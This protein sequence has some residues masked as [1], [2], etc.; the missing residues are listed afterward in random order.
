MLRIPGFEPNGQKRG[1]TLPGAARWFAMSEHRAV[2]LE[3]QPIAALAL[4]QHV[5]RQ[6]IWGGGLVSV[7]LRVSGESGR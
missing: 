2:A 7:R 5:N 1:R 3:A 4:P 6:L